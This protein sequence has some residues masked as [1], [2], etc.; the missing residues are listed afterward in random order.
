MFSSRHESK[1]M[2]IDELNVSFSPTFEERIEE[3]GRRVVSLA[4]NLRSLVKLC[5]S[6]LIASK[7]QASSPSQFLYLN[8]KLQHKLLKAVFRVSPIDRI[9]NEIFDNSIGRVINEHTTVLQFDPSRANVLTTHNFHLLCEACPNLV[10]IFINCS[11]KTRVKTDVDLSALAKCTKLQV[12]GLSHI[13]ISEE[14]MTKIVES[15]RQLRHLCLRYVGL[16]E[17]MLATIGNSK[18]KL[19]TLELD[20]QEDTSIWDFSVLA[21]ACSQ[22]SKLALSGRIARIHAEDIA[23]LLKVAAENLVEISFN[24]MNCE[25]GEIFHALNEFCPNVKKISM[26][27][28]ELVASPEFNLSKR[29]GEKLEVLDYSGIFPKEALALASSVGSHLKHLHIGWPATDEV[30]EQFVSCCGCTT[31]LESLSVT[32]CASVPSGPTFEAICR[33]KCLSVLRLVNS[34]LTDNQLAHLANGIN[35]SLTTLDLSRSQKFVHGL[36]HVA[37]Y[38]VE[39]RSLTADYCYALSSPSV[40][41]VAT[42]CTKL[43]RLSL[44]CDVNVEDAAI[45]ALSHTCLDLRELNLTGCNSLTGKCL[46]AGFRSVRKISLHRNVD[47]EDLWQLLVN[48]PRLERVH[49]SPS[50][51][52]SVSLYQHLKTIVAL[53]RKRNSSAC[54]TSEFC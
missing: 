52:V 54:L 5:I 41:A 7:L 14:A 18:L 26:Q 17:T 10:E 23:T 12:L 29:I 24:S 35:K 6:A 25:K 32:C 47:S 2:A 50:L 9:Q 33:L 4:N 15:C 21:P 45:S 31:G 13:T 39:L 51:S 16:T 28:Y 11:K 40:L 44:L 1:E 53:I 42:K 36:A 30:V 19:G 27:W 34:E 38:C 22:C 3:E 37:T 46:W 20:G 8:G 48:S 43:Q 49:L